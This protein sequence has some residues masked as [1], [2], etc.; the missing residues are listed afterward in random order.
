MGVVPGIPLG[1]LARPWH[2]LG[3]RGSAGLLAAVAT[4]AAA[5]AG[6][7]GSPWRAGAALR[8]AA[9]RASRGR[10]EIDRTEGRRRGPAEAEL[11][12]SSS[13]LSPAPGQPSFLRLPGALARLGLRPTPS[14]CASASSG[15]GLTPPPPLRGAGARQGRA[16]VNRTIPK[17]LWVSQS[18]P[19]HSKYTHR[20]PDP[21]PDP[22]PLAPCHLCREL[23]ESQGKRRD[24][25]GRLL[26][27]SSR[28]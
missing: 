5:R 1:R 26:W 21:L 10:E 2:Y 12:N 23:G 15:A 9:R 27:P 24:N 11:K 28:V 22:G 25:R 18:A 6:V 14:F 7:R 17:Y 8:S 16:L 4:A 3:S 20:L 19:F 13:R